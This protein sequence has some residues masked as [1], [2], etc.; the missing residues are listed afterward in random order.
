M[1]SAWN[2]DL[3]VVLVYYFDYF[4]H[5][6]Y[7]VNLGSF[8]YEMLSKCINCGYL[9][10]AT[11]LTVFLQLFW[12]FA[13]VFSME[14]RCACGWVE[15]RLFLVWNALKV[16]K[17]WVPCGCNFS[18]SFPSIVLK[19]CRCFQHGMKMCMWL[20]IL[21]WVFFSHSFCFVN[22]V[23]FFLH[24]MLS[25]C[26]DSGYLVGTAL[27]TVFSWLFWNFAD[28]SCMKW[29]WCACGFGIIHDYFF[30]LFLLCELR[31]EM[32]P[33][34]MDSGYL[35][36]C[37]SSYSFPS[38]VLKLCRHFLNWMKLCMWFWYNPLIFFFYLSNFQVLICLSPQIAL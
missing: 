13:D 18:Y 32:L 30:S 28:V 10:G 16:Y 3:H 9:V 36:V 4:S 17:L 38:I 11:S 14:W 6:F 34:L 27:L 22:F 8:W 1:F 2:E 33:K 25:K 37:N 21:L 26:I 5:F 29:K 7:F 19:L 23:F 20:G 15:L 31:H 12:N 24:Q 35:V